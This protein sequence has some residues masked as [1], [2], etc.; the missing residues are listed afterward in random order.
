MSYFITFEGG[1]GVGKSTQCQLL[2]R[3]LQDTLKKNVVQ[4]REPGGTELGEALRAVLLDPR[5]PAMCEMSELLLMFAARAEH[6]TRLIKP[7]LANGNIVLCDRFTDASFAY[8]GGGR[9]VDIKQIEKLENLVQGS[10]TPDL[11][12]LL[13]LDPE[14]GLRRAAERSEKDRF[15]QERLQFFQ[16]VRAA[17]LHRA[18]AHPKRFAVIDAGEPVDDIAQKIYVAVCE[19]FKW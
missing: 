10:F 18:E 6:L 1:E 7:A 15:E 5:V 11:T 16:R 12:I 19:K 4:T 3:R 9:G 8:Q 14:T 17:Y 13:D 2:A